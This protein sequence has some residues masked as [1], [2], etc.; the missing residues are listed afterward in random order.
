MKVIL[1]FVY[2]TILETEE[3]NLKKKSSLLYIVAKNII[4]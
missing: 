4:R 1:Q 3:L 2:L